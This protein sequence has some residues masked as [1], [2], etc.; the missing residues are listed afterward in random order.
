MINDVVVYDKVNNT[1]DMHTT[2]HPFEID[3]RCILKEISENRIN[4][5]III[6]IT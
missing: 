4:N 2:Y 1:P 6:S 3:V 5:A